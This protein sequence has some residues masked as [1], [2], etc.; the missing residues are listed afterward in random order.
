MKLHHLRLTAIG[1][2]AGTVEIDLAALGASGMFLLEGPTG[3][4]KS[5]I[6]DAIAYALY[7]QVAGSA[8]SDA[9]IR[10][11]FAQPTE[12][13]VV[14]LVFETASGI[15]RV[16]R[17]P[18]FQRPKLRGTGTTKEQPKAVLWRIGSPQLIPAVIADEMGGGGGV[19]AIATR[20]DE[21][22]REIQRAVGLNR[23][24]FTQTVLLP[25]NEFARFLRAGTGERQQV[26]Q[27]VFG[28]ETYAAVEKQLEEMRKSAK[29]Q[30]DQAQQTLGT[31]LA[32]FTEATAL[33]TEQV[34][35]L[36]D[37]ADALRLDPLTAAADEHL[38]AVTA[39]ATTTGSAAQS[40]ATAE[41]TARTAAETAKT[42]RTRIERRRTLDALAARLTTEK[43]VVDAARRSL[44]R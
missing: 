28:T 3:S 43:P 42:A 41:Q 35:V 31:A 14:D 15:Y 37:H 9:R 1:P 26:L 30:V 4:G 22:G 16:R 27:R 33:E 7:G 8:T 10:S 36:Q 40:A 21:V 19:E 23:D 39:R 34:T 17:Q 12:A 44:Q 25:Q 5:T 11:Q 20:I 18:E 6:L 29:R 32:R 13:S 24:Q 2:F 38:A